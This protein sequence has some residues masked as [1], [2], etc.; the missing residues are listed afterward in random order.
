MKLTLPVIR[1]IGPATRPPETTEQ[2]VEL[3]EEIDELLA[4]SLGTER[5]REQEKK[6]R[7]C[8]AA[9]PSNGLAASRSDQ[10][11]RPPAAA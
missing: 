11:P 1:A 9:H 10:G 3:L 2:T 4:E 8:M 6:R 7:A 5:A